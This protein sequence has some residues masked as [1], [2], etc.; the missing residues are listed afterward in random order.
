MNFKKELLNLV[1]QIP[2]GRVTTYS[3][4]AEALGDTRAARAVGSALP[5]LNVPIHRVVYSDDSTG[6][7]AELEKE[8]IP[9]RNGTVLRVDE[10]VFRDF[11]TSR[12]L[13]EL[14]KEQLELKKK[15][16]TEDDFGVIETVAGVDVAYS[17]EKAFAALV[18]LCYDG[19]GAVERV[20]AERTVDFPY[21]PT[22]LSYREFPVIREVLDKAETVPDVLLVDGNGVLHPHSLGIATHIGVKL[23]IPTVG[24]AKRL[25]CGEV[26]YPG[27]GKGAGRV[28]Y[29]SKLVGY[30]YSPSGK[31]PIYISPGHRVS[32]ETSLKIVK[33]LCGKGRR[34]PEPLRLAHN[35][36]AEASKTAREK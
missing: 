16:V 4:L 28:I 15:I 18:S 31:K 27:T 22:Y 36:A 23:D 19:I 5:S 3:E 12:P 26:V 13:N 33:N 8:G 29:N 24:V 20:I 9:L 21:I 7:A 34:L 32:F 30:A 17:G 25:L 1:S 2:R 14:R 6:Y 10:L 11:E 35:T